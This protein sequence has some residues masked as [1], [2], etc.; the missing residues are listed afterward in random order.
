[1]RDYDL[2]ICLQVKRK[3]PEK[4]KPFWKKV[5]S[6]AVDDPESL[7]QEGINSFTDD[8]INEKIEVSDFSNEETEFS[9][10][11]GKQLGGGYGLDEYLEDIEEAIYLSTRHLKKKF[12]LRYSVTDLDRE[13]DESGH[14]TSGE[15]A[16][17]YGM[18][19]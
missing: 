14:I 12:D 8:A 18:L 11:L 16:A 1:M 15:L 6:V 3:V 13:P 17:K 4:D 10:Q 9:W 2:Y 5:L 7:I 19:A